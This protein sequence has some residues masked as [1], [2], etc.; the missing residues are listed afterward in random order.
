[1]GLP[2]FPFGL[3]TGVYSR[4]LVVWPSLLPWDQC[5]KMASRYK[6]SCGFLYNSPHRTLD[7]K[8][9]VL[10]CRLSVYN[11]LSCAMARISLVLQ[12]STREL[13]SYVGG[14]RDKSAVVYR[15]IRLQRT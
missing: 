2:N 10:E 1:M 6:Q 3:F 4:V 5:A 15:A 9:I 8:S 7:V 12:D 14:C 13:T 11:V